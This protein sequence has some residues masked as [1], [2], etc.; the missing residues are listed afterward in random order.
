VTKVVV[1]TPYI[2]HLEFADGT[3]TRKDLSG[4]VTRAKKHLAKLKDPKFFAKARIKHGTVWWPG[5]IDLSPES[6]AGRPHI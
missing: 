3:R 6:L 5:E 1:G 4:F 2:L